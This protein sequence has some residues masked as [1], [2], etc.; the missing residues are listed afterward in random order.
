VKLLV[1]PSFFDFFH[2]GESEKVQFFLES[3][4]F[5][6]QDKYATFSP[7]LLVVH[8][9]FWEQSRKSVGDNQ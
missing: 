4:G 1:Q 9:S 3:T 7:L 8:M 6:A 5:L 2:L